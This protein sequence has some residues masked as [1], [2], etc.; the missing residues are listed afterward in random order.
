MKPLQGT[1]D[2]PQLYIQHGVKDGRTRG[3]RVRGS[4]RLIP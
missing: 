3:S 1:Q 2:S 4:I